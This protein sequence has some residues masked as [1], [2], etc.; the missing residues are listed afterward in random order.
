MQTY[1]GIDI[2]RPLNLSS[3][4]L[5]KYES[6]KLIPS[7]QR[8]RENNYRIY[9]EVHNQFF[10]QSR[11]MLEG[12]TWTE[13]AKIMS[14]L[15]EGELERATVLAIEL[16]ANLGEKYKQSQKVINQLHQGVENQLEDFQFNVAH[17]KS[18]MTI[19]EV[20]DLLNIPVSTLRVWE[21][22]NLFEPIRKENNYRYFNKKLLNRLFIIK[23]LRLSGLSF[24]QCSEILQ[25]LDNE[26]YQ[27]ILYV[28]ESRIAE[29]KIEINKGLKALGHFNELVIFL[30]KSRF[31]EEE[32]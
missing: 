11:R 28:L 6:W 8:H 32:F 19:G 21:Q 14:R 2:T 5:R 9:T 12:F 3:D 29:M 4:L 23:L 27:D 13:V 20:A 30:E 25:D 24:N 26:N 31:F 15:V 17:V 10:I 16:Q 7:A 18:T 1:R 22:K